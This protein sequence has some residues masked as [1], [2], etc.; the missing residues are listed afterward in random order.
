M[1]KQYTKLFA[2]ITS[3]TV[4]A[5]VI[6]PL[7]LPE[8]AAAKWQDWKGKYT[9]AAKNGDAQLAE[10]APSV[11]TAT[12]TE[13]TAVEVV[14]ADG[15]RTQVEIVADAEQ[16]VRVA[17]E[18]K[19]ETAKLQQAAE[20]G[21]Q[22]WL[23]DPVQVVRNNAVKYGF[24]AKR[25]TFTLLSQVY[26]GEYSGTG[27]A[28]VL[29]GHGKEYYIVKV[30]QPLGPGQNKIWQVNS[31]REVAVV[32]TNKNVSNQHKPDVGPGVEGLDYDKVIKWQQNVDAGRELWRLDPLQVA[33]NEGAAFGFT[34][35][36]QYTIVKKLSS[37]TI[38][39]HGQVNVEVNHQGK[40]YTIILVRPFGDDDGAIWTTYRVM[41]KDNS[42]PPAQTPTAKVLF[43]TD[44]FADWEWS[45][46][47]YPSDMAF[48]TIVDYREQLKQDERIPEDVLKQV[49]DVDYSKQVILFAYL[50]T[51]PS[52]GYGIG[53][54]KVSITGNNI[55]VQVRTMSPRPGQPVTL[56]ITHP[57]D[58]VAI[59]RQVV[60]IWG[61]V[62]VNF[63]DQ[64]GKVLSKNRLLINH[65]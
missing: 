18:N 37:S 45:K 23:L 34:K 19:D 2:A 35:N 7:F 3:A 64:A 54:E 11:M 5:A 6:V 17:A 51:A 26:Q 40:K 8:Q 56:A 47:A 12:A 65:R 53:I 29:V 63:V 13:G 43:K 28:S 48:A 39:R 15:T 44:E 57:A 21:H 41:G 24:D 33:I 22:P 10:A 14:A 62:N 42:N 31:I 49:Q 58:Y 27:E 38:A 1:K 36:D 4:L 61:G 52:G 9:I 32:D 55:T 20:Q 46:G 59:D 30:I 60:D 50:G 16:P 25:D